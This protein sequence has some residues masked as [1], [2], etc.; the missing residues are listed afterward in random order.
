MGTGTFVSFALTSLA[1][2]LTA[3]GG[4]S[5]H[6]GPPRYPGTLRPAN[7]LGPDVMMRQ[8]L[9]ADWG[10]D[11]QGFEAVLQ[12]QGD[13]MVLLG[14]GPHGGRAFLLEHR[15][16]EI[17]FETFVDLDLPFP[18][19]YV[20]LD[21]QRTFFPYLSTEPLPDGIH[22]GVVDGEKV[23]ERWR[24]GRLVERRF[25]RLDGDPEGVI[26][27]DYGPGLVFGQRPPQSITLDNGWFGYTLR[28]RTV[29]HQPL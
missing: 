20:L 16:G 9:E 23:T 14:L 13:E 12:K 2:V 7:E 17:H 5:E 15:G 28:V 21:V 3:C 25:E 10:D 24:D 22:E 8:Q 6:A 1:L 19:R 26:R 18:P 11:R 4:A 27:V 29:D